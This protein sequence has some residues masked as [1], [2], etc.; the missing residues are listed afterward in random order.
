MCEND[1][2]YEKAKTFAYVLAFVYFI[3]LVLMAIVAES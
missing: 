1:G 2:N 3:V